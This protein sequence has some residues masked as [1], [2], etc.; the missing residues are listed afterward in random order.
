MQAELGGQ[1]NRTVYGWTTGA[2]A[3]TYSTV[4]VLAWVNFAIPADVGALSVA[5]ALTRIVVF[6][7]VACFAGLLL[8]IGTAVFGG[9]AFTWL[10]R[11]FAAK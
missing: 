6:I 4:F 10:D 8:A 5:A 3:L 11:V 2:W 1:I 7:V 9:V